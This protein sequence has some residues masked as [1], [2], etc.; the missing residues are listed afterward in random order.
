[1]R[2][3]KPNSNKAST[4]AVHNLSLSVSKACYYTSVQLKGTFFLVRA[5]SGAANSENLNINLR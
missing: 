5:V 3:Y 4:G 2:V 1:M